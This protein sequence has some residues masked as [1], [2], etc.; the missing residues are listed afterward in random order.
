MNRE[1]FVCH[2]DVLVTEVIATIN[3]WKQSL[4]EELDYVGYAVTISPSGELDVSHALNRRKREGEIL[5][6]E[7]SPGSLRYGQYLILVQDLLQEFI[8]YHKFKYLLNNYRV[9]AH[10]EGIKPESVFQRFFEEHP[11]LVL[12]DL[13]DKHWAQP[14]LKNH[15]SDELL[16]PDFVLRPRVAA[17]FGTKWQILD[18]K[19][20]DDQLLVSPKFHRYV[21]SD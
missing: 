1:T 7:A 3:R 4:I 19:L 17:E 11:H 12:R 20:P 13:F 15:N 2:P 18:L 6:N 5:T 21:K 10:K 14:S 8:P 9:I 16:R